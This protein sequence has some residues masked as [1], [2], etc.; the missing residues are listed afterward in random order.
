MWLQYADE[1]KL[2]NI[3]DVKSENKK[4]KKYRQKSHAKNFRPGAIGVA[5]KKYLYIR[6]ES[7]ES[8]LLL[9]GVNSLFPTKQYRIYIDKI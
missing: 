7:H 9:L 4:E 8:L 2:R 5:E 3:M 6:R 1:F